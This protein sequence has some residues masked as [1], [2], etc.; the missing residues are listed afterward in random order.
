M[1]P[2]PFARAFQGPEHQPFTLEGGQPATL[3]VHGFPGTPAE[4]H[5]LGEAL[6]REG[7][8]VEGLLLPGFGPQIDTLFDRR[9][10]EWVAAIH[11]ALGELQR[12]H[13]PVLLVG[14][15]MGAALCL[16]TLGPPTAAGPSHPMTQPP[17]AIALLA[18]FWKL[19]GPVWGLLPIL[20]RILP[21][22]RPFHLMKVNF[23]NP[24]TRQGLANFLPGVDLDDLQVQ[25]AIREFAVPV[26]IL[27][28]IRQVGKVAWQNAAQVQ[29][30]AFV[31]QG[32]QDEVVRP[33]LTRRLAQ[34]LPGPL[35]YLEF[36]AAHNL[37][38]PRSPPGPGSSQQCSTSPTGFILSQLPDRDFPL[39]I[40]V[41]SW[42]RI[43]PMASEPHYTV[44]QLARVAGVSSRTLHYYDEI[45]LLQPGRDPHNGYRLY[46]RPAVLRLQQI[47]FLREL[48]LSLE[49]IQAALDRPDFDLLPA[50]EQH[51]QA[52]LARQERLSALIHTV[53]RTI[54]HLKGNVEMES[55]ELFAGFSE[56]Q[57]KKY[58]EEAHRRWGD[59]EV[60]ESQK[61]WGSYSDE[62]KRQ[63]MMEGRAVY[64]DLVKAMPAGPGSS[65][66]GGYRPLAPELALLL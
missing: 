12:K 48:G 25:S 11:E 54:L 50:L 61:R 41:T 53:E 2:S 44:K 7:W 15:S 31:L 13:T 1:D 51:R 46:E 59:H 60:K 56:E 55:E 64:L 20:R 22:F 28:E 33:A 16:A 45:G 43:T 66:P 42:F 62:K 63:I 26:G 32:S 18:P 17:S 40:N 4:M 14:Y 8:T 52:L 23:S 38:K 6:H 19:P 47:L 29:G 58:E 39:D 9:W 65:S 35:E 30:P 5:P 37:P 10:G 49:E 57:Q 21:S 34:R 24:Q 27:D 3:L 36:P